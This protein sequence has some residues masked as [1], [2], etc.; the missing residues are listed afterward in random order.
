MTYLKLIIQLMILSI[1]NISKY[2]LL[3]LLLSCGFKPVYYYQNNNIF[4]DIYLE[5]NQSDL[6]RRFYRSMSELVT[7]AIK[8]NQA[9]YLLKIDIK[10]QTA[11]VLIDNNSII[12]R[13]NLILNAHYLITEIDNEKKIQEG[14]L[15]INSGYNTSASEFAT[16]VS[17][18]EA[19]RNALRELANEIRIIILTNLL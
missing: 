11:G 3:L 2:I 14:D 19:F 15:K 16:Y 4:S 6:N 10:S 1:S 5:E 18:E 17:E 9:K 8:K 7:L 12:K 13:T